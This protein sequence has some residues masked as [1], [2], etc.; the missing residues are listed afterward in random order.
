VDAAY[1]SH[2]QAPAAQVCTGFFCPLFVCIAPWKCPAFRRINDPA[3]SSR[4][5][6]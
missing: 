4:G 6:R 5:S 2:V 3:F 1:E